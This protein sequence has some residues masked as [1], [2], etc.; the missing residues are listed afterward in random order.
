VGVTAP[1]EKQALGSD[2]D[3]VVGLHPVPPDTEPDSDSAAGFGMPAG[4]NHA[5]EHRLEVM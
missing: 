1:R 5:F 2:L 3:L 4:I